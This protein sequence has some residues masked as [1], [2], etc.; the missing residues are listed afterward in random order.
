MS[1]LT[2]GL[3]L[4]NALGAFLACVLLSETKCR[5]Q[6]EADIAP[7]RATLLG[8]FFMTVGFEIDLGI[9]ASNK[10]LVSSFLFSVLSIKTLVTTLLSYKVFN[11]SLSTSMQT[12]LILVHISEFAFVTFTLAR[13]LGKHL[14]NTA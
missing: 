6:I 5:H 7:F 4:S 3:G 2:E 12:G 9:I 11:L 10:L 13:N 8:F 1:F 14:I